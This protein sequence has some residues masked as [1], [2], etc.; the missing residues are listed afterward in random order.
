MAKNV[1][2]YLNLTTECTKIDEIN[3]NLMDFFEHTLVSNTQ[4]HS[5]KE[6]ERYLTSLNTFKS[7]D[8]VLEFWSQNRN[9]YPRLYIIANNVLSIPATN[10]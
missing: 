2:N 7:S 8:S 1:K 6:V 10:L 5:N 3:D 9:L 4:D